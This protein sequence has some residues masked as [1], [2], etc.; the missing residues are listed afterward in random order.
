MSSINN[1]IQEL[2]RRKVFTSAGLYAFSSFIIMQVANI[3]V[4]ALHLPDWSNT[5]ILILL[6]L[7]FPIAM[8]FAWLYDRTPAGFV[9]TN[10]ESLDEGFTDK[11]TFPQ[12]KDGQSTIVYIDI[13]G[14]HGVTFWELLLCGI[15]E[16]LFIW[17]C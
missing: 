3:I 15:A 7:G 9:K 12:N 14:I 16:I 1:Y 8:I 10:D 2:K 6:I 11:N 4:P 5:L 17:Y 13:D